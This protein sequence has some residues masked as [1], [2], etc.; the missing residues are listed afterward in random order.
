MA[1]FVVSICYSNEPS[2]DRLETKEEDGK[3]IVIF[4]KN[5][6]EVSRVVTEWVKKPGMEAVPV[7]TFTQTRGGGLSPISWV[8]T[9]DMHR[10]PDRP[11]VTASCVTAEDEDAAF[12]EV[13]QVFPWQIISAH[14]LPIEDCE[15]SRNF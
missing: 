2:W 12:K 10:I 6:Q 14:V 9:H 13:K 5:D 11:K 1:K 15:D 7:T 8:E 3:Q 4:Y